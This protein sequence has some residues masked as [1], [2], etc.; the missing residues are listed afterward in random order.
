MIVDT[1]TL[2]PAAVVVLAIAVA[3]KLFF[4]H[5]LKLKKVLQTSFIA[6]AL[7]RH[8]IWGI[9]AVRTSA[10]TVCSF[11][12]VPLCSSLAQNPQQSFRAHQ[13]YLC[14]ATTLRL[15]DMV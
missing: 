6:L 14:L 5:K 7:A 12:R 4:E 15:C 10:H 8:T 9:I 11:T 1:A 3:T 2:L 13:L